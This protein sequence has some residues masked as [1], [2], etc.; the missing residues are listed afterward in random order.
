V[1]DE[2]LRHKLRERFGIIYCQESLDGP[3]FGGMVEFEFKRCYKTPRA[4][5][6]TTLVHLRFEQLIRAHSVECRAIF[7]PLSLRNTTCNSKKMMATRIG[8]GFAE[9]TTN[10][11]T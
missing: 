6:E 10:E 2:H 7:D 1:R 3:K 9:G 5:H 4:S 11:A 8:F